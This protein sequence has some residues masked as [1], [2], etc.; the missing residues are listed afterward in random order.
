MGK[1]Q[2]IDIGGKTLLLLVQ[3]HPQD[4][5]QYSPAKME[6]LMIFLQ[7]EKSQITD[8]QLN[9]GSS[10]AKQWTAANNEE[11]V[12]VRTDSM[13]TEVNENHINSSECSST[14]LWQEAKRQ[15]TK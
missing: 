7:S 1:W 11:I 6:Q 13:P 3:I 5:L 8:G 2:A 4:K 12:L 10:N 15:I 9:S 14:I